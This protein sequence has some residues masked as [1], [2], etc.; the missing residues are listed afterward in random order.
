M[1]LT[2]ETDTAGV[3]HI[4]AEDDVALDQCAIAMTH[5]DRAAAFHQRVVADGVVAA[6]VGDDF[7]LTVAAV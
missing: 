5:H 6:F 7:N 4:V 3:G 1:V 2:V